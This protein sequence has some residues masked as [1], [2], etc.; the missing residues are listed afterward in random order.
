[1][2]SFGNKNHILS[3][4]F[5]STVRNQPHL[6]KE[7]IRSVSSLRGSLSVEAALVLPLFLFFLLTMLSALQLLSFSIRM[8]QILFEEGI[9]I[10]EKVFEEEMRD[11][12]KATARM[13]LKL[14]P[15]GRIPVEGDLQGLD[16]SASELSDAEFTDLSVHYR[17][18]LLFDPFHLFQRDLCQ[19]VLFHTWIGYEKGLG[20]KHTTQEEV[21]VYITEDSEVYHRSRNCT[22]IKLNIVDVSGSDVTKMRN[23]YGDHYQSCRHCHAKKGDPTLYITTDGDCYHNSLTCSGLSRSVR[24]VPLRKVQDRRPCSRCGY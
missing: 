5:Q 3:A 11:E 7:G 18:K 2:L 4:S 20:G 8:Q 21:Y 24:M 13:L 19:H 10:S 16:F 12:K 9:L 23:T 15:N 17:A 1:M 14:H 6:S 22:H